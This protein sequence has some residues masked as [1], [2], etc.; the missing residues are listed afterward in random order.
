[1]VGLLESGSLLNG[2]QSVTHGT[3]EGATL[4][5]SGFKTLA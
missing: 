1:M 3:L 5:P 4:F 2:L